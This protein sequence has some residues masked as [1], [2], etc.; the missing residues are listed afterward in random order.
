VSIVQAIWWRSQYLIPSSCLLQS[1]SVAHTFHH[2]VVTRTL[3]SGIKWFS[4]EAEHSSANVEPKNLWTSAFIFLLVWHTAQSVQTVLPFYDLEVEIVMLQSSHGDDSSGGSDVDNVKWSF[5]CPGHFTACERF[6]CEHWIEVW[7][8]VRVGLDILEI[9]W[10]SY[11]FLESN[12]G[13]FSLYPSLCTKCT[14]EVIIGAVGA[15]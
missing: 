2:P 1:S 4:L 14:E 8:G 13:L 5:S 15:L 3:C 9:R 12:R 11:P 7:V 6:P 10:M